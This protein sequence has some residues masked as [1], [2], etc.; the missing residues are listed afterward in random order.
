M[1][2]SATMR[3]PR[4]C[5][6]TLF[7]YA[8]RQP[9]TATLHRLVRENFETFREQI[10]SESG[11]RLP[12]FVANEFEG[13]LR[14]GVLAHG[15]I[16][17]RC[18]TCRE[19]HLIGFS[20]KGRGF[21]PSCGARRMAQTAAHLVDEILPDVPIRQWVLSLPIPLRVLLAAQPKLLTPVLEVVQRAIA[22]HL[23]Q[24]SGHKCSNVHS[25]AVT[26]I[27]RFGSAANLNIHFHSLVLDGVYRIEHGHPVF[28]PVA[29]P[30][31]A[32][33]AQLLE[34]IV[35]RILALLTRRGHWVQEPDT[36][37][38]YLN[39]PSPSDPLLPLHAAA[40]SYR[41]ALGP[42]AGKKVM[43]I[44]TLEAQEIGKGQRCVES[45]GF[46][47]H[48]NVSCA[49]GERKKLERLCRYITRPPIAH[50]RLKLSDCGQVVYELKTPYRDG[51]THVVMSPLEW[52]Q[53]LAALVPRPRLHLTRYH[54]ILAPNAKWRAQV[55]PKPKAPDTAELHEQENETKRNYIP[56]ARLLKRV[57][58]LDLEHCPTCNGPLKLIAV[59]EQAAVWT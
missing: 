39:D 4:A 30:T 22:G 50:E 54:G 49:R 7:Q 10:Y 24:K 2:Q 37:I 36:E 53:R 46:S 5:S 45:N 9:E 20:C 40:G 15:F 12:D 44:R 16:R 34:R 57:F 35:E 11:A 23:A 47:L 28:E 8:R 55:V 32:E 13:F 43:H 51:T 59:I 26:L 38:A 33:L 18:D 1:L 42:R 48:A 52:M 56:W 27:Q 41:I 14:C 58:A 19:D 29:P 21:C 6:P 3:V 17:L 31:N 25:G